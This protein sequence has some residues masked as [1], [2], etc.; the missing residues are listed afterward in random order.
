[1]FI[2]P[3]LKRDLPLKQRL[4]WS[5]RFSFRVE[6]LFGRGRISSKANIKSQ[7]LSPLETMADVY[8]HENMPI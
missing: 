7:K 6:P 4:C 8:H 5:K 3:L 2:F 1:M